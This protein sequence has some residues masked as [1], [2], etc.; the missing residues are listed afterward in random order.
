MVRVNST[1]GGMMVAF[2][3]GRNLTD[4]DASNAAPQSV[5]AVLDN[6]RY[7]IEASGANQGKVKVFAGAASDPVSAGRSALVSR[8][9]SNTAIAGSNASSGQ[10]FWNM[11]A[12]ASLD[13]SSKKGWFLDLP[14]SAER[15]IRAPQFYSAGSNVI[16]LVS[17]RPAV[18]DDG[19]AE[20][21]E[22]FT[23]PAKA[24]RTLLGIEFGQPPNQQ[25]L[26]ANGDGLYSSVD[27]QQVNRMST[28]PKQITLRA[29]GERVHLGTNGT[30]KTN[31]LARPFSS[32]NW[33][34]LQ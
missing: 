11:G 12:Q 29:K 32:V 22:P 9:F 18:S 1:V 13:Y 6:T 30:E 16:E 23:R 20:R 26:D 34:Q 14:E 4:A 27:D 31:E 10:E 5:Y 33:R 7:E 3:T 25:L 2:G 19:T 24:W 8:S 17:D 15:V 28:S 21:C